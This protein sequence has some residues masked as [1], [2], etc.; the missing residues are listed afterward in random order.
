MNEEVIADF[1]EFVERYRMQWNQGGISAEE[2]KEH[3]M[4]KEIRKYY[5]SLR[6]EGKL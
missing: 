5:E 1:E 3:A 6:K 4:V 2:A